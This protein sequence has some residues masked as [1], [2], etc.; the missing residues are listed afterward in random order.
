MSTVNY[1]QKKEKMRK[2]DKYLTQKVIFD[3]WNGKFYKVKLV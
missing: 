3:H 2:N 1:T